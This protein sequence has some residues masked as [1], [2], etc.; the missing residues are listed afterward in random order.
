MRDH[1]VDLLLPESVERRA[2]RQHAANEQMV[3]LD[4]GLLRRAVRVAEEHPC[5]AFELRRV[6]H[7]LRTEELDHLRVRELWTVVPEDD[8]EQ[9]HEE[10]EPRDVLQPV[11]DPCR[12][13]RGS[14]VAEE[15]EHESGGE[16]HREEHLAIDR[17]DDGVDLDRLDAEVQSEERQVVLVRPPGAAFRIGLRHGLLR[18]L[19]PAA[20]ER[21]VTAFHVEQL[22]VGV[23]VDASLAESV[24]CRGIRGHH[25]ADGLPADS[26]RIPGRGVHVRDLLFFRLGPAPCVTE[27]PAVV[28][29]RCVRDVEALPERTDVLPVASVADIRGAAESVAGPRPEALAHLEALALVLE[30]EFLPVGS[31]EDLRT[32]LEVLAYRVR[33]TVAL[34]APYHPVLDL[35][36]DRGLGAGE[37][38]GYFRELEPAVETVGD[39]FPCVQCHVVCHGIDS[40]RLNCLAWIRA[41]RTCMT[42]TG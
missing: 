15:R 30:R 36:G 13:L 3:V 20:H 8:R 24:E 21:H 5:P 34:V 42:G 25:G 22:G 40:F 12:R 16:H 23:V 26:D 18:L 38:P 2:F 17:S 41:T 1:P 4:M 39:S 33:A 6:V 27:N 14:G 29:L 10:L 37:C 28:R 9:S 32:G 31:A 11:E 19:L 7:R 35:V